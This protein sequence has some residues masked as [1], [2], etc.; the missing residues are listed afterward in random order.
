M[1]TYG[2]ITISLLA[3]WVAPV[4]AQPQT[5]IDVNNARPSEIAQSLKIRRATADKVV[6]FREET[7][8]IQS[9]SQLTRVISF[10]RREILAIGVQCKI[11]IDCGFDFDF[12][13]SKGP[14]SPKDPKGPKK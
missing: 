14:K 10:S 9:I 5:Q 3:S 8:Q 13:P 4:G 1:R 2:L 6:L 7:G 12:P 11:K